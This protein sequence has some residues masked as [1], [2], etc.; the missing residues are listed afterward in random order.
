MTIHKRTNLADAI[1]SYMDF[2]SGDDEFD[3]E[4]Y[5]NGREQGWA[6]MKVGDMK[7]RKCIF[8]EDRNTDNI[9]VYFGGHDQFSQQGNVPSDKVYKNRVFF[10]SEDIYGCVQ[11]ILKNFED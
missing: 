3:A 11:F 6:I 9:V 7:F 2:D 4:P 10:S 5:K 8:S 1:L